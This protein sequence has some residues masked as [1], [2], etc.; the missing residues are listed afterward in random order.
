VEQSIYTY[1]FIDDEQ[2][3][4]IHVPFCKSKCSYCD[5]YRIVDL[6]LIPD[7]LDA[8]L[9][10]MNMMKNY[11]HTL[12]TIYFGGGT[13]SI[14][15]SKNLE[16]LINAIHKNF[17]TSNV[18]EFT[19]ECNPEDITE[20]LIDVLVSNKVNRISLGVQSLN[21]NMLHFINR[22]HNSKKV[23]DSINLLHSKNIT[24]ISVDLIFGYPK[25]SFYDFKNDIDQ[26]L[27]LDIQHLSAYALSYEDGAWLT[28]LVNQ[29][30][31]VPLDDDIVADQYKYLYEQLSS[32]G[33]NHYEISNY[34]R[35]NNY[36]HH[37]VACWHRKEYLGLG[38]GASSYLNNKRWTNV[39][40]VKL[41]I[42]Q[43]TNGK[44]SREEESLT[45]KDIYN[46]II[47][48]GFRTAEGVNINSIP[49]KYK[50]SFITNTNSYIKTGHIKN[51]NNRYY[52][53]EKHWFLLDMITEKCML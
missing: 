38:P 11:I 33:F 35:N 23:F 21:D 52:I 12:K 4:Y 17:D 37:N 50:E 18:E 46:E 47:M 30:K 6:S 29:G 24:N 5:F 15:G 28:K 7:Y 39:S 45:D 31:V 44:I 1:Y 36:S 53:P 22:R 27:K 13:P 42:D 2:G 49:E 48:L 16:L 3:L 20:E 14:L 25:M 8:L 26:F 41:Y 10:E 43:V 9:L 32:N 19:V 34:C 40:D 51:E